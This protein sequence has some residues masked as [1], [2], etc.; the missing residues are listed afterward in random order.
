[1]LSG[2]SPHLGLT[3]PVFIEVRDR[4]S[5]TSTVLSKAL[6]NV[7]GFRPSLKGEAPRLQSTPSL[8]VI[9]GDRQLSSA[10]LWHRHLHHRPVQCHFR[11]IWDGST[12]S[13]ASH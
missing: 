6:L 4:M 5:V 12:F 3:V 7:A 13:A 8:P 1:M 10:T 11:R 9:R 2:R